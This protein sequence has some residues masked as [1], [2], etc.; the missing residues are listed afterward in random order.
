M[1]GSPGASCLRQALS[2][3]ACIRFSYTDERASS[4]LQL[5]LY[6]LQGHTVGSSRYEIL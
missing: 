6:S 5:Q 3:A 1:T 2:N 4:A